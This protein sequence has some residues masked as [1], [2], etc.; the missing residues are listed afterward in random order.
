MEQKNSD[1]KKDISQNKAKK[2]S[3]FANLPKSKKILTIINYSI[4]LLLSIVLISFIITMLILGDPTKRLVPCILTL[5]CYLA[6][7]IVQFIF[8]TRLN[9]TIVTIFVVFVT[10]SAFIGSCLNLNKVV[11]YFDK[12]QHTSWGYIAC[13]IGL[14]FLCKTKEFDKLKPFTIIFIFFA[15]SMATASIWELFEFAGDTILGQTAQGSAINGV[16]PVTDTMTDILVHFIGTI[17]F[18]L[19]YC[20]DRFLQK[21]LGITTIINDFKINY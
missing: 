16:V 18:T 8:K 1:I 17:I 3:P 7:F 9:P 5:L 21:N 10:I 4:C 14:L 13:L 2:I 11:P 19:H 12:I 15:V 6:P 20:L